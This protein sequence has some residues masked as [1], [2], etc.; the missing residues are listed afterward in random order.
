M[1]HSSQQME[2]PSQT[3]SAL[4]VCVEGGGGGGK[5]LLEKSNT[6]TV[7]FTGTETCGIPKL[8]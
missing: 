7:S 8:F 4:C 3:W 5:I 6:K 2:Q 1:H